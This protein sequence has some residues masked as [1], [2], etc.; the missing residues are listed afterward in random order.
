LSQFSGCNVVVLAVLN[1]VHDETITLLSRVVHELLL[2]L[3]F[4]HLLLVFKLGSVPLQ[5]ELVLI[6]L[7][8]SVKQ[9][10]ES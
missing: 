2:P 10:I 4:C 3:R 5:L 9:A 7:L 1:R 8:S 6:R